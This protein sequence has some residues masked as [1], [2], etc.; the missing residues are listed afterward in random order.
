MRMRFQVRIKFNS[1]H[2]SVQ[3]LVSDTGKVVIE[4]YITVDVIVCLSVAMNAPLILRQF[5]SPVHQP[6]F[7]VTLMSS[8]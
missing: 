8:H 3:S 4:V 5:D 2:C 7:L 6:I 1:I